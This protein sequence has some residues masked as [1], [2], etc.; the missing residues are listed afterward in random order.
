VY[1]VSKQR[2]ADSWIGVNDKREQDQE[3]IAIKKAEPNKLFARAS[4]LA[5]IYK[6]AE[7]FGDYFPQNITVEECRQAIHKAPGFRETVKG[8][9][10]LFNYD[11]AFSGSF[12]DPNLAATPTEKRILQIRRFA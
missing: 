12:P 7:A 8:D 4:C 11:Y 2:N 3:K 10:R 9:Y 1:W 5:T 6:M